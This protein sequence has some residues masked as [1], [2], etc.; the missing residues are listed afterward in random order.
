VAGY[1]QASGVE[2]GTQGPVDWQSSV[3]YIAQTGQVVERYTYTPYGVVTYRNPD[4]S[5]ASSSA[6]GNTILY[7]GQQLDLATALY[8]C[9]A[10]YYDPVLQRFVNQDPAQADLNVYR[11]CGDEPTG[12][13]DPSGER[14]IVMDVQQ[15]K[16][17]GSTWQQLDTSNKVF[18]AS[19][20]KAR[21][22]ISV[23]EN[24]SDQKF[25]RIESGQHGVKF[26]RAPFTGT[27][28]EYIAKLRREVTCQMVGQY[29]GGY[30]ALATKL[31]QV[32]K[33]NSES[34]DITD[35]ELHGATAAQNVVGITGEQLNQAATLQ[36]LSKIGRSGNG[37]F[38]Y[39]GNRGTQYQFLTAEA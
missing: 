26:N 32:V 36:K 15:D 5:T 7:T 28:L 4:W 24:M 14:L 3:D 30:Q 10:R 11:Y 16:T 1:L 22:M 9:R 37:L 13:T 35:V 34:Y 23:L 2:Q 8:Y 33:Y 27:R 29:N 21:N 31:A 12:A 19:R 20:E 39:D 38:T 18:E 25:Q 17:E 6:N